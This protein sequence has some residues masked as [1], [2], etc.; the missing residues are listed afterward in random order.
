MN[1]KYFRIITSFTSIFFFNSQSYSNDKEGPKKIQKILNQIY[2][3]ELK[4]TKTPSKV[5]DVEPQ[6]MSVAPAQ[7]QL[8]FE[9]EKCRLCYGLR[10]NLL[11]HQRLKHSDYIKLYVCPECSV[12]TYSSAYV[13]KRHLKDNHKKDVNIRDILESRKRIRN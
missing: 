3:N 8:N 6:K 5:V 9:C 1:F 2:K 4:K 7:K 10:K 11:Y 13:L 12:S